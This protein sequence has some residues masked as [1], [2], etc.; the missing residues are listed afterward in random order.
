MWLGAT[1]CELGGTGDV[2]AAPP[3]ALKMDGRLALSSCPEVRAFAN[4]NG[5]PVVVE[6]LER[7]MVDKVHERHRG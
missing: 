7:I 2:F 6:I 5:G 4:S 1:M 3:P